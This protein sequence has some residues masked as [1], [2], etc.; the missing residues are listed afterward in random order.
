LVFERALSFLSAAVPLFITTLVWTEASVA[1]RMIGI[2]SD[3]AATLSFG[4][5]L[6]GPMGA[7]WYGV[8]LWVTLGNGFRYGEKYLYLSNATS[9]LGFG[10]VVAITPTWTPTGNWQSVWPLPCWSSPP[11]RAF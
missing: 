6:T 5:Y 1:K 7:P 10:V 11:I 3:I 2:I 9:L 4:L 8:Y